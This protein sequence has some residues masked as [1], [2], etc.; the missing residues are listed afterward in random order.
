MIHRLAIGIHQ[1]FD[2]RCYFDSKHVFVAATLIC[3]GGILKAL[4]IDRPDKFGTRIPFVADFTDNVVALDR[5]GVLTLFNVGTALPCA[6]VFEVVN[7]SQVYIGPRFTLNP[8]L[9]P[10]TTTKLKF[11]EYHAVYL[12]INE[13]GVSKFHVQ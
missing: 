8:H 4:Q 12:T 13:Y 1:L 6:K 7:G 10:R 9:P 3:R 2:K 5:I 11:S